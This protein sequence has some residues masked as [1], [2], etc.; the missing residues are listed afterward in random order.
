M[1]KLKTNQ[2]GWGVLGIEIDTDITLHTNRSALGD[3]GSDTLI[4]PGSGLFISFM[5]LAEGDTINFSGSFFK[6]GREKGTCLN[7]ISVR[8]KER[9]LDPEYEFKFT[10][11][12]KIK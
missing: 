9:V 12:E 3:W 2:D 6:E 8:L 1:K 7:I 5:N 4:N 10:R 11:I